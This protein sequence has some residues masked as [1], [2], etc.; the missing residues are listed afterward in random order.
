VPVDGNLALDIPPLE[1]P[2]VGNHIAV[3]HIGGNEVLPDVGLAPGVRNDMPPPDV[4]QARAAAHPGRQ[5]TERVEELKEHLSLVE[6]EN[7]RIQRVRY[8]NH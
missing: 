7:L 5:D 4:G 2:A 8:N 6:Q 1:L 3:N